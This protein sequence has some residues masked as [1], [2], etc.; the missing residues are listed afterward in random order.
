MTSRALGPLNT[1]LHQ[2]PEWT[3]RDQQHQLGA[4]VAQSGSPQHGSAPTASSCRRCPAA[5]RTEASPSPASAT[6]VYKTRSCTLFSLLLLI[7]LFSVRNISFFF[8]TDWLA[9]FSGHN[10]INWR[11]LAFRTE[12]LS[13][14]L[15][16]FSLLVYLVCFISAA[17]CP[18]LENHLSSFSL[19]NGINIV[20]IC[21]REY[22]QNLLYLDR[23]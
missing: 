17:S 3:K 5:P 1:Q 11:V 4:H 8:N 19:Q 12:D 2:R 21:Y 10:S 22:F 13:L 16:L 20:Y 23:L 6:Q 15:C 14:T 18:S 7:T 9:R